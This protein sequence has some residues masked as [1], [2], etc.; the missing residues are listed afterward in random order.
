MLSSYLPALKVSEHQSGRVNLVKLV[1]HKLSR[2]GKTSKLSPSIFCD[3]VYLIPTEIH[4]SQY[5]DLIR[6]R[7]F[8]LRGSTSQ[9][10]P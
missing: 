9:S 10:Q 1:L 6:P 7:I 4:P 3:S 5:Q 2:L 8:A